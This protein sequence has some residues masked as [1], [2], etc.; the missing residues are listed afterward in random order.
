MRVCAVVHFLRAYVFCEGDFVQ[1]CSTIRKCNISVC[2]AVLL[3]KRADCVVRVSA[4]AGDI[5]AGGMSSVH[6][7]G[8]AP[9][10]SLQ[11]SL[12]GLDRVPAEFAPAHFSLI[13]P[14]S[15]CCPVQKQ[16]H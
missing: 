9:G 5:A 11:V 7:R 10:P 2:C 8:F 13:V 3:F 12:L 6:S 1:L 15:T 4:G 14:R 16:G